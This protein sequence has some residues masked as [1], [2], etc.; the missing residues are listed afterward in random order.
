MFTGDPVAKRFPQVIRPLDRS[1][2]RTK[3]QFFSEWCQLFYG[4]TFF[5]PHIFSIVG[6]AIFFWKCLLYITM[7]PRE[8]INRFAT[9][10]ASLSKSCTIAKLSLP[11]TSSG[12]H[13]TNWTILTWSELGICTAWT[14]GI[15][16]ASY[17][18]AVSRLEFEYTRRTI[19]AYARCLRCFQ[20]NALSKKG[21]DFSDR[22]LCET[23]KAL[24]SG[25]LLT[26]QSH[27]EAPSGRL[28]E[29]SHLRCLY[30]QS[31]CWDIQ[32]YC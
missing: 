29:V 32:G 8:D 7:S 18:T 19:I 23:C 5:P 6:P 10:S 30:K 26:T 31:L 20:I 28:D 14:S 1:K 15:N 2:G 16:K 25:M 27:L 3:T 4:Q 12:K 24:V 13:L 17:S 22:E 9:G 11:E 21:R